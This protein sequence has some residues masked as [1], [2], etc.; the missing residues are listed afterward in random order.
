MD[1]P[2]LSGAIL[3]LSIVSGVSGKVLSFVFPF[4]VLTTIFALPL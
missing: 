4:T 2:V 3:V 1:R